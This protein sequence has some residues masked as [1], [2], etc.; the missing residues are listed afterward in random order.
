[1]EKG[2]KKQGQVVGVSL[3]TERGVSKN[4]VQK[5]YL[6]AGFGLVGDA[7]AGSIRPV[8]LLMSERIEELKK[9]KNLEIEPGDLAENITTKGIDLTNLGIGD[10]LQAGEAQLKVV[11]LGKDD[12][13]PHDFSF[14]GLSVLVKEGVYCQVV[15]SG[16]IE[17]GNKIEILGKTE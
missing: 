12:N 13:A 14:H 10:R 11:Q 9:E 2:D 4:N 17:I 7:H 15:E 16:R 1:M 8:S 5:G 3:N 6:K